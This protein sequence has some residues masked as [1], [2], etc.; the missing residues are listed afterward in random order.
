MVNLSG[1]VYINF[2]MALDNHGDFFESS[3]SCTFANTV[4]GNFHLTRTVQDTGYRIG[5]SHT[6]VIVTVSR[7]YGI[8]NAVYMVNQVFYLGAIF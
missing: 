1:K 3:I 6:Q 8:I 4:D 7:K 5:S 2:V